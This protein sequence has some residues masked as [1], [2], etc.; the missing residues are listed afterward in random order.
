MAEPAAPRV[1][2]EIFDPTAWN[3]VAGFEFTDITYHRA[4]D[5]GVVRIA[6]DRPEIRNAF[7]PHTVDELF[8]ALD[9]ARMSTDVGCAGRRPSRTPIRRPWPTVR[10]R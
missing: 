5:A 4:V 7:R 6:F 8:T 10:C 2:S 3:N 1:V 9:H